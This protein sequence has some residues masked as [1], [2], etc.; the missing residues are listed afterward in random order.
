MVKINIMFIKWNSET[1]KVMIVN[2]YMGIIKTNILFPKINSQVHR[3]H[4]KI[5]NCKINTTNGSIGF[6]Y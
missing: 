1:F 4:I 2:I 3:H 5:K 6:Y